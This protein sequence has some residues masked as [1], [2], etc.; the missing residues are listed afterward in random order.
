MLEVLG[1][2]HWDPT[3]DLCRLQRAKIQFKLH[4]HDLTVGLSM[5]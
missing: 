1:V 4:L 2:E 5:A 3:H